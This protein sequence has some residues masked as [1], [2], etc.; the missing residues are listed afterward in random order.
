MFAVDQ[1]HHLLIVNRFI[2]GLSLLETVRMKHRE[3]EP[4]QL[5]EKGRIFNEVAEGMAFITQKRVVHRDLACANVLL[6]GSPGNYGVKV[7]IPFS[8]QSPL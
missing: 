2:E 7:T 4:L 1:P 5:W 6:S 8:G 3:G